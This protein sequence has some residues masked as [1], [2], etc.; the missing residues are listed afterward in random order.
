MEASPNCYALIKHFEG[1]SL[2]AYYDSVK[3]PTIGYGN[4]FYEDG[5]PVKMGDRI[6]RAR[7]ETL[8][9]AIVQKFEQAVDKMVKRPIQQHE[10]DALVSFAYNCGIGNLEK[11]T[12]LQK[13]NRNKPVAEIIKEFHRWNRAGGRVLPGLVRRRASEAHLYESGEVVF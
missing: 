4:T 8:L 3:I 12:L 2:D 7:A 11:S 6:T 9:P 13:V 5:K 1:L 10:F